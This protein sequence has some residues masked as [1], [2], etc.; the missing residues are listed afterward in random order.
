MGRLGPQH[1]VRDVHMSRIENTHNDRP[2]GLEDYGLLE[3]TDLS[4][5]GNKQVK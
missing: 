4:R 1:G 5:V 3:T 2:V